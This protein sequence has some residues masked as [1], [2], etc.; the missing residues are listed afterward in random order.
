MLTK[1]CITCKV[2]KDTTDFYFKEK[3][4]LSS[5]CKKCFNVR[6]RERKKRKMEL[7]SDYRKILSNK[8]YARMKRRMESD[9]EYRVRIQNGNKKQ[10]K[11]RLKT[12][13]LY[14]FRK[15]LSLSIR[16]LFKK[17]GYSKPCRTLE[18]LGIDDDGFIKYIEGLFQD[19]M[20]W[21]NR[22]EW[23]TDHIV[24]VSLGETI[25]E[26][27]YLNHHT[28]LRPLWKDENLKKSNLINDSNIELYN[29]FLK[30]MRNG[31]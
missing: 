9:P 2:E 11:N 27:K 3:N 5:Y 24:P 29:K 8:R 28:N 6:S 23:H 20:T 1:V 17:N 14:K 10:V 15:T 19:G 13:P 21:Q 30:E 7:N 18:I 25:D 16:N 22:G 26:I 4:K 12:D 31:S